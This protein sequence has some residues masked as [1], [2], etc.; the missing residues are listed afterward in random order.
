MQVTKEET[1]NNP[2]LEPSASL[3]CHILHY[4][5]T[6]APKPLVYRRVSADQRMIT[7]TFRLIGF[8]TFLLALKCLFLL[9]M[10]RARS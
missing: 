2:M 6:S 1:Q 5:F 3:A 8:S 4:L 9:S 10:H 7:A